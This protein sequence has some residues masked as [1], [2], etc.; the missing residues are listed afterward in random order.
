MWIRDSRLC[1][2]ALRK[3]HITAQLKKLPSSEV[4]QQRMAEVQKEFMMVGMVMQKSFVET[5]QV[6][7]WEPEGD[8]KARFS[9]H[10]MAQQGR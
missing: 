10:F 3:R 1:R 2:N 7:S 5:S 8:D 6:S 4:V 9:S